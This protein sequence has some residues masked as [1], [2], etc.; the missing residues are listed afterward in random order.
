MKINKSWT[1]GIEKLAD[2]DFE[3]LIYPIELKDIKLKD[4]SWNMTHIHNRELLNLELL[5]KFGWVYH[6]N[7]LPGKESGSVHRLMEETH[8][9]L[10][11]E[12]K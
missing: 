9:Y 12:I 2:K 8:R 3:S 11:N 1:R 10:T 5:T 7:G 6:F 4:K